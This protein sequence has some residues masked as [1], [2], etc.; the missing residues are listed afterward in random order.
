MKFSCIIPVYNMERYL[1]G[2]VASALRSAALTEIL[3]IDDG[4]KDESPRIAR[5]LAE[6]H[7]SVRYVRQENMGLSEARN[8][9]IREAAGD[10]LLFLDADDELDAAA[11]DALCARLSPQ[12]SLACGYYARI[13]APGGERREEARLG[14]VHDRTLPVADYLSAVAAAE[15]H[16]FPVAWR[17][18][19]SRRFLV[20]RALFFYP[21]I[22]HEDNEWTMRLLLAAERILPASDCFYLYYDRDT[23]DSITSVVRPKHLRDRLTIARR[24]A[25]LRAAE[26]AKANY[27]RRGFQRMLL[28]LCIHAPYLEGTERRALQRALIELA[29]SRPDLMRGMRLRV[30][31]GG[32]LRLSA[33][34]RLLF[35]YHRIRHPKEK[36]VAAR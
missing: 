35:C 21:G 26:P 32:I 14:L 36:F 17:M 22:Y 2:C 10:F 28:S 3:L 34:S 11:F 19:C 16:Y 15:A 18:I 6:A 12:D 7:A 5:A 29:A 25:A 23:G 4:S 27:L 20:E 30:F 13:L 1:E 9:G 31:F 8:T 33:L 24:F